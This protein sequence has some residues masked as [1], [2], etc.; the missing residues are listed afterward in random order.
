MNDFLTQT[1]EIRGKNMFPFYSF[2][3]GDFLP[4]KGKISI[5]PNYYLTVQSGSCV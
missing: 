3:I 2:L 1:A 5:K 4:K